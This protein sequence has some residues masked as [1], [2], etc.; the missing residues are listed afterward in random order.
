MFLVKV[1]LIFRFTLSIFFFFF[2]LGLRRSSIVSSYRSVGTV[3]FWPGGWDKFID[4]V[5]IYR[6]D[7][8]SEEV[9]KVG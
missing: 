4:R 6:L 8:M 2:V 3:V 1:S 5:Y 7:E 9:N